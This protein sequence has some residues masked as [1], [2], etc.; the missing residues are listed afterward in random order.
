VETLSDMTFRT[1][2]SLS[3]VALL[4]LGVTA[5][6][7][8]SSDDDPPVDVGTVVPPD[9]VG[10]GAGVPVDNLQPDV[11]DQDYQGVDDVDGDGSPE[12]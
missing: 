6:G 11:A 2:R 4:A 9:S 5:C 10:V 3:T 1:I 12:P 7:S 8:D